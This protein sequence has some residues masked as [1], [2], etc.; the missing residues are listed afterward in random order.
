MRELADMI[1]RA[2]REALGLI[3]K[4]FAETM[5]ELKTMVEKAKG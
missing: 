4:R 5:D 3:N 2:N 1:Q